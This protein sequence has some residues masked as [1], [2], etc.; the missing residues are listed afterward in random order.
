MV[1]IEA[2]TNERGTDGEHARKHDV[3]IGVG[4]PAEDGMFLEQSLESGD[5]RVHRED[6]QQ[7][8][9]RDGEPAPRH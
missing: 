9:K 3:R 5:I 7:E 6:Q 4:H 8:A 2:P 1:A